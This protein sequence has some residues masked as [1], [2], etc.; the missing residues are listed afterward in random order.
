MW[1]DSDKGS[2]LYQIEPQALALLDSMNDA[3]ALTSQEFENG[4]VMVSMSANS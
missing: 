2:Y 1:L 3:M 4:K